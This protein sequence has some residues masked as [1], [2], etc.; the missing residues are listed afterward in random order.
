[1]HA[2]R[3]S[4]ESG[5]DTLAARHKR[6]RRAA[7]LAVTASCAIAPLAGATGAEAREAYFCGNGGTATYIHLTAGQ[8][9]IDPTFRSHH[10]TLSAYRS[11]GSGTY[12][13]G[14]SS[15][16]TTLAMQQGYACASGSFATWLGDAAGYAAYWVVSGSGSFYGWLEYS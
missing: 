10:R 14:P 1:M 2:N 5:T 13:V 7:L 9:C 8:N 16:S 15:S 3:G 12:C 11:T 4:R 6:S